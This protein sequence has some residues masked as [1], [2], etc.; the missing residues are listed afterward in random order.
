MNHAST[1]HSRGY[2]SIVVSGRERV[3]LKE[4]PNQILNEKKFDVDVFESFLNNYENNM[5]NQK[6]EL[7]SYKRTEDSY[8]C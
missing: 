2:N 6:Y 7:Q 4:E 8:N 5:N 3:P 1:R